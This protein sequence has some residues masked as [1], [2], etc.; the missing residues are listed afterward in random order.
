MSERDSNNKPVHRIESLLNL[1][2]RSNLEAFAASIQVT[3]ED[4]LDPVWDTPDML[5]KIRAEVRQARS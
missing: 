5:E 2:P 3:G 1:P 4:L